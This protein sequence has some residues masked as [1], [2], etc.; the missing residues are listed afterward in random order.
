MKI[1]QNKI[2]IV[3]LQKI[4]WNKLKKKR[5]NKKLNKKMKMEVIARNKSKC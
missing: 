3:I 1:T 2:Q 5:K 4:K